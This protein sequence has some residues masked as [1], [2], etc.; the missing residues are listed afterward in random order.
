MTEPTLTLFPQESPPLEDVWIALDIETTGLSPDHDEIIE[1]GAVKFQGQE[2]L[3]TFQSFVNPGRRLDHFVR[4]YTGISQKDVDSAPAFDRVAQKLS[5]FIGSTPVVGHNLD[6]DLSL[7]ASKGFRLSSPVCDTWDMAYVLLPLAREYSLTKISASLGIEHSQPHRA[8]EDAK[9]TREVFLRLGE[10]AG[11]V[12]V[13]TLA[14]MERLAARSSWVMAYLLRRLELHKVSAPPAQTALGDTDAKQFPPSTTGVTG[15]DMQAIRSRLQRPR[16]LRAN[17]RTQIVDPE[18]VTSLLT[19]EGPLAAAIPDFEERPEQLAMGRAVSEAI[20]DGKR[21]IV[22]AGTGVGKSLAY[23][24]PAALYA[25]KNNKRVVVSTNTINLQEQLLTKDIPAMVDALASVDGVAVDQFR[26]TQLKGRANYLCLK[27]F[28]HLRSGESLSVDEARLL[29]K[30]LVWLRD[31]E[32]GDRSELNLGNRRS[33]APWDRLSAQGAQDC[34][35]VNGACFLRAAR[36]RAAASHLVVVNHALLMSDIVAGGTLIPDHDILIVDEAHHLESEATRH[37]GFELGQG[38][39]DDHLQ[40]LG[41]DRGL[42]NRAS[43]AL[44][45]S[46]AGESRRATFEEVASRVLARLPRLRDAAATMFADLGA[47]FEGRSEPGGPSREMRV[48]SA[49]RGQPAWSQLEIQ[50]ENVDLLLAEVR[51]EIEALSTALDGLEEAGLLDYEGL[52]LEVLNLLQLTAE[53]RQQLTEFIPQPE[54]DRIYWISRIERSGDLVLH[55]APLHVGEQLEEQLFARNESV[56]LTSATLSAGGTFDHISERTGF[57]DA[58]ELLLG[59]P[60]DYPKA[61]LMC[62]PR[63]MPEPNSPAYRAAAERAVLDATVASD[64]RTMALFTSHASLQAAAEGIRGELQSRGFDVLAQGVDGQPYQVLRRFLENPKSVLL[65]TASFWEGVDLPGESLRVLLVARLPFSV[66][67]EP[68]FEARSELYEDS[69]GAYAI[70]QAILRL[71]QG[72][73]R[74]I[75]TKTDRGVVIILDRRIVSRRYGKG[76][77]DSLPPVG[78]KS[79][80]LSEVG[81]EVRGWL[82]RK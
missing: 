3:E 80:R 12:D 4:H 1:V 50:W 11:E 66:P 48:T 8:F 18:W 63:D 59:S 19:A 15:L 54:P 62:V 60:F 53:L 9:I 35:G 32:T 57:T 34:M 14:E 82:A 27:R 45:G 22:E 6:F 39:L 36:D 70:P 44:R 73:G 24:L 56:I 29:S 71:R 5:P 75:R 33:A 26:F 51:R 30:A 7:L 37:L 23:L 41:G 64:G 38:R 76:F 43:M 47:I 52:V 31:T 46:S 69:F 28:S 42:L 40:M 61:A 67:T 49:T 78:V 72:F 55:G 58:D 16:A 2:T 10:L 25:L 65:G 77:L 74:L 68:V 17:E 79:C 21:L 81:D 20:N 13:Y